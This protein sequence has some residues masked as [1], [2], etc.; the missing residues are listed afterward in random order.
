M[1]PAIQLSYNLAALIS[2]VVIIVISF[3]VTRSE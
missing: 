2:A 1:N 3:I